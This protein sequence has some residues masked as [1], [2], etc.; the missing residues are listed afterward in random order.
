MQAKT[1]TETEI[2]QGIETNNHWLTRGILAIYDRQTED[3]KRSEE[4]R[5]YNGVGYNGV[6]A[7]FASSLA[8]QLRAG[9][10]LSP[11][12]LNAARKMMKKYCGQLTKIANKEI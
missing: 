11:K 4:T 10:T 12:Q 3:E 7:H 5:H 1:Y 6:D 9:Y 8:Q 2:R